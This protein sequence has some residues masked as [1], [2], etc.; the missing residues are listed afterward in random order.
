MNGQH[1][2]AFV[3]LRWRLL[4]NATRRGGVA[5]AVV[6][7]LLAVLGVGFAAGMFV[8][9]FFVG[10]FALADVPPAVLIFAWDGLIVAFLFTWAIGLLADLQRSEVL[11]LDKFLH[12]PVSVTGAFLINYLSS[13][14]SLTLLAFVPAMIGLILGLTFGRGPALLLQLP[15]LAALL[16]AVTALTY[17]FQGW[18]ASLMTN[19]RRRRTVIVVVTAV[20]ILVFQVPNLMNILRPWDRGEPRDRARPAK[21]DP[22]AR[23]RAEHV[24]RLINT[25][26]PPGWLPLGAAGLAEGDVV[27]T[28]LGTGGLT[29]I[30]AASLWRAYRTTVRLY[31]GDFSSGKARPAAV[32]PAAPAG[33][34][35]A[36]LLEQELPWLSEHAAA[37]ALGGLRSLLRAPEA[38]MMLLTPLLMVVIVGSILVT[39]GSN[40]PEPAR[41]LLPFAAMSLILLGMAQLVGNQFGFDRGGFRVFVLCPARRRDILLGKN[42]AVAPLA[43]GLGLLSAV[44]V[45]AVAPL[46]W[47]HFLAVG[48]Q[49]VSMYLLF[50]L[51]GNLLSIL[52]PMPIAAGTMKPANPRMVPVLLHVAFVFVFPLVLGPAV[53]P[54]GAEALLRGLGWAEAAPV[55]LILSLVLGAA[56]VFLY[57]LVVSLEGALLHARELVILET[58]TSKSE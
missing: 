57:R 26:L 45:Q 56:V 5:N 54:L 51:P 21:E 42:L 12:L 46:R 24:A 52:A 16:L 30:G 35:P 28:L 41:P 7:G 49:L 29:L 32:A 4:V 40:I 44:A 14:F 48:P 11:S 50:C 19:P 8:T 10:M 39:K 18:L 2:R 22:G 47:D 55:N 20:F 37:I 31:K 43:L 53:V 6:L 17:Q 58:V 27:P 33:K 25:V 34:A 15:L 1:L 9:F 38:K 36:H 3:W 13:L 23:Q